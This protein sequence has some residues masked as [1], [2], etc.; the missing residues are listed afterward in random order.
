MTLAD[1]TASRYFQF[2]PSNMRDPVLTAQG[3]RLRAEV[4]SAPYAPSSPTSARG[5]RAR[6]RNNYEPIARASNRRCG[7]D[8]GERSL[9]L[10]DSLGCSGGI[11]LNSIRLRLWK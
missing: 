2:T 6:T 1:I 9:Q 11:E 10:A 5:R 8:R 3:D 4:C 7:A